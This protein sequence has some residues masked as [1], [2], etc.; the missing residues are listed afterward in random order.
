M[1][2]LFWERFFALDTPAPTGPLRLPLDPPLLQFPPITAE[3][4][5]LALSGT[6]SSAPGLS[7][8]SYPLVRWAFEASPDVFLLLW[9]SSLR[10]HF[11]P[12]GD[13]KV[14]V[15]TKPQKLDYSLA[16]AYR[17][18]SL[19]ECHGKLLQK[20]IATQLSALDLRHDLLG[21]RQFGSRKFFSALDTATFLRLK[22]QDC[23]SAN[24]IGGV[25]LFDL[26]CFFDH[27]QP[28]VMTAT[29]ASLGVDASTCAWIFSFLSDCSISFSFNS[30]SS[31]SFTPLCGTP[32]GSPLSPILSAIFTS[33]LFQ[34]C[35]GGPGDA[36][37]SLYVDDGCIFAASETFS[38]VIAKLQRLASLCSEWLT[39]LGLRVDPD[40]SELMFFHP[41]RPSRHKGVVPATVPFMFGSSSFSLSPAP[42]IRYLG[43]FF[44]PTLTWGVH[45][46]AL[47]THA[48]S[49]LRALCVLGNTVRGL[50]LVSWRRIVTSIIIPILTYGAETWFTD[51]RQHSYIDT[52]Q[53]ALNEA[54]RKVGGVFR[55]TPSH[56]VHKLV[57][58]PPIRY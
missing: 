14:I 24:R 13:A 48:R 27:I 22:A 31:P 43:I 57:A 30:F 39:R 26:S 4:V 55:T 1:T 40:K 54:C 9:N 34:L 32:Q 16:K 17:P 36:D 44:T 25:L 18:I 20:I 45:V 37:L 15:I 56:L 10:L 8:I 21:P 49:S 38:G 50:S 46:N 53:V 42:H 19:L 28:R 23:I 52:L 29:L 58:I 33:P 41:P 6:S 47:A 12:W 3:E 2:Q 35:L 11:N 51:L 7:G 5:R